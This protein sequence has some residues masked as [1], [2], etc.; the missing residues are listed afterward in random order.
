M[1]KI[2]YA[3]CLLAVTTVMFAFVQKNAVAKKQIQELKTG[4]LLVRLST[5]SKTIEDLQRMGK[6][7]AAEEIRKQQEEKNKRI[8]AA[9]NKYFNFC[10]YRFFYSQYSDDI[11]KGNFKFLIFNKD[12]SVDES[13]SVEGKTYYVGEFGIVEPDQT[14]ES[15]D[16]ELQYTDDFSAELKRVKY[17][18]STN[19]IYALIIKNNNYVQLTRPFPFFATGISTEKMVKKTN[20]HL[21]N[22]YNKHNK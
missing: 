18:P 19:K 20:S 9:F 22:F 17:G 6:S 1:K 7:R 10:E 5:R 15:Y 4:Y 13:F 2:L 12:L 16:T 11:Q 8:V 21:N 14:K 3:I